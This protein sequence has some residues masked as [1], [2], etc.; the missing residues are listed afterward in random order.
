[1]SH[2]VEIPSS[3]SCMNRSTGDFFNFKCND[4]YYVSLYLQGKVVDMVPK[5][6]FLEKY[7][8]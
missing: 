7:Q 3:G 1:M 2:Q 4:G 6:K 5:P 8:L